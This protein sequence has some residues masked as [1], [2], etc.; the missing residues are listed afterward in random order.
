MRG[1]QPHRSSK[2]QD[3]DQVALKIKGL[4]YQIAYEEIADFFHNFQYIEKSV[5]LGLGRDGRKNGFGAIL[6]ESA[7]EAQH[8]M[9][10]M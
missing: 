9:Q 7:A 6:F 5:V 4:P 3:D 1:N 8:A 10:D 2:F